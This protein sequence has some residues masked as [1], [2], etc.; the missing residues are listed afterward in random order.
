MAADGCQELA[1]AA[2][3]SRFCEARTSWCSEVEANGQA[4]LSIL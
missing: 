4:M 2:L 3:S 1:T